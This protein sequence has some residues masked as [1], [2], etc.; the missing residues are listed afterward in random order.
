MKHTKWIVMVLTACMLLSLGGFAQA[1]SEKALFD[2]TSL[3]IIQG[4]ENGDYNLDQPLTRAEF[5]EAL[6][7]FLKFDEAAQMAEIQPLFN[8]VDMD[9]WYARTISFTVQMNLMN[10]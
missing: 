4:D 8:D 9:A 7:K 5:A 1:A 10:G 2:I 6:L 3:G